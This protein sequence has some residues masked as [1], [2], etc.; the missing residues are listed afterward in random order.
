[1]GDHSKSKGQPRRKPG[2]AWRRYEQMGHEGGSAQPSEG[3]G[4]SDI[5][6]AIIVILD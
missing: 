3:G 6:L 5:T 4:Y 2:S 1:M